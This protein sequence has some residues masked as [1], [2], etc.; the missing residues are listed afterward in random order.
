[1]FLIALALLFVGLVMVYSSSYHF[2]LM[3]WADVCGANYH[4]LRQLR[5]AGIGMIGLV[6][7][8]AIDY[9]IY[10]RLA[11][12]VIGLT[13][14][15]LLAMA[16]VGRWVDMTRTASDVVIYGSIQPVEAAKLGAIIYIAVWLESKG[17]QIKRLSVGTVP[18]MIILGVMAGLITAQPDYSTAILLVA[19]ASAMFFVAGAKMRHFIFYLI[20]GAA[21][22]SI[23][24]LLLGYGADRYQ[25][26]MEG[27]FSDP[28]NKGY[29]ILQSLRALSLGGFSGVG[30]GQSQQKM[31]LGRFSHTDFIFSI[32]AEEF[33]F[34]GAVAVIGLYGL[35]VWR[36]FVIA[37]SAP[38]IYGRLL[39][40]GLVCWI[41]LQAALSIAVATNSA[42][43]TGTV[44]PFMSYGG[45]SLVSALTSVGILLNISRS[46]HTAGKAAA[47]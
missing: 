27:P 39:A 12:L 25:I 33:G 36:G 23:P 37:R 4:F 45:S 24:V 44:L 26:W 14:V 19:T 10:K 21:L 29:Q 34:L 13:F 5:F 2:E 42:P 6:I 32:I 46:G 47:K 38:D 9:H 35:W 17:E 3:G 15:T 28:T 16:A 30:L 1:M 20:A 40:T 11:P 18:F 43:V 22:A 7:T 8:W 41:A 31:Y